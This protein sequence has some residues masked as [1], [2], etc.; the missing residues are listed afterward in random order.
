MAKFKIYKLHFKAPLHISDLRE[1]ASIS[2]KTIHSDTLHA[3]LIACLAKAGK[4][5][6][7]GD[8]GCAISDLFP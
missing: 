6:D 1:D 4:V 8:L 5:P 7:N 2:Q 3:A